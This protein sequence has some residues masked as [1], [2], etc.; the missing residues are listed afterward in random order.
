MLVSDVLADHPPAA[1]R[2]CLIDR[3]WS[4]GWDY[5]VAELDAAT[6]KLERLYLAAGRHSDQDAAATAITE[7]LLNDLDVSGAL[8]IAEEAGGV[9]ARSLIATLGLSESSWG[10]ARVV[11]APDKFK[12]SVTAAQAAAALRAGL[13]SERPFLDVLPLPVADGGEG[14][15]RRGGVGR[16]TRSCQSWCRG[17]PASEVETGF[18]F[19]DGT[20]VVE[21]ADVS[22]LRRLPAWQ[23]AQLTASTF[24]V[25]QVITA[26]LDAGATTIVLGIG[27]SSSTDGGA[28]ML[29]ALGV[30]LTGADGADLERGGAALAGLAEI[31]RPD[32]TGGCGPAVVRPC[33]SPAT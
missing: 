17:R 28:G 15:A 2:L 27:G 21:L 7:A 22:G 26:A 13:L 18:A 19:C 9:A 10:R 3:P 1:L 31:D 8:R 25:G 29:Q 30:R 20:A 6:A 12:D 4:A 5:S 23:G 32:S 16:T 33:S 24:G 14:N 11:V